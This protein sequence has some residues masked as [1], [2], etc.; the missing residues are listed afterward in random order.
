MRFKVDIH[1]NI[2]GAGMLTFRE[3][4]AR[5]I[6]ELAPVVYECIRS[7]KRETGYRHTVI[8]K[9]IV[10]SSDDITE[11]VRAIDNKPIPEM[12]DIFR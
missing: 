1:L 10:N 2:D 9:V 12:D 4:N 6:N 8:H 5:N 11:Q 3:C 7:I